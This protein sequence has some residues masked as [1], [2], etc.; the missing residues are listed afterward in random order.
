M[1]FPYITSS[2][3]IDWEHL[4]AQATWFQEMADVPQDVE[5]H[6]EGN[7]QVH[8]RMV[9]EAL[10]DIRGYSE[11][12]V[13]QK[14]ILLIAAL[15]HDIEKRSCTREEEQAGRLRIVS[16]HHA[17]KGEGTARSMLYR[18]HP[19]PT[20]QREQICKLVRFHGLPLWALSKS[21]PQRAV[22]TASLQVDTR[23][24]A[25]LAEADVRGRICPDQE[26]LLLQVD[27]F[28]ELCREHGCYG[29]P[30]AFASRY[31]RFHYLTHPHAHP[32]YEPYEKP[33][34]EVIMLSALPGTGKDTWIQRQ[35]PEWPQLSLDELRREKGVDPRNKKENGRII[36]EALE[37]AKLYLRRQRSFVFNATNVT[38]DLRR[39]W[40]SLF[41]DYH[42]EIRIVALEV[43]YVQLL[44]Q[45]RSREY[46]LPDAAM[47]SLL[48]KWEPPS[49]LEAHQLEFPDG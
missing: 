3:Q 19:L 44:Q 22:I 31:G 17:R 6:A 12:T 42:A 25:M 18:E 4:Q 41:A 36:Q 37:Q 32:E 5:W 2:Q 35:Y 38:V 20:T 21:D 15:L 48:R 28:R 29:Q 45:N 1:S 47:E 27:L 24:L 9:L 13:E 10:P 49:L 16:P 43:P 40:V 23:L 46:A 7:V 26:E 11:L 33:K 39:K 34:L 30:R 14:Q 8:T